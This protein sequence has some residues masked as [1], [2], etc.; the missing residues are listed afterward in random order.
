MTRNGGNFAGGGLYSDRLKTNVRFDQNLKRNVLEITFDRN[1]DANY[2]IN[3]VNVHKLL[4]KLGINVHSH[5]QA[6]QIYP[7]RQFH[8]EVWMESG[9][10]LDRFC[11][12]EIFEVSEGIKTSFIRPAG[13]K[14][15][16]VSIKGIKFNTPDDLVIDYL[17][18]KLYPMRSSMKS[19]KKDILKGKLMESENIMWISLKE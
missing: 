9:V 11:K 19:L 8:M 6:Y 15:V 5:V 3:E 1:V 16:T 10:D 18:K 4:T 12:E 17:N 2:N 7:G 14:D 13:R